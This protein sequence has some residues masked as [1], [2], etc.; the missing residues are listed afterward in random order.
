MADKSDGTG[1]VPARKKGRL[2]LVLG[3]VLMLA[4]GGGGFYAVWSGLLF[5]S[6]GAATEASAGEAGGALPDIAFVAL[7]PLIVSINGGGEKSYL[8]FAAQLEVAKAQEEEVR[9]ILPR[10]LDVLN[11]YL[12][13]VEISE[14]EKPTALVK[15][16]AQLVR[17]IQLVAGE[18]RVRDLLVTEF[19]IN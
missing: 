10:V 8:R 11:S 16:R 7:D 14:L 15:L 1:E 18:G 13:A 5:G 9:L 12:R 17:R 3:V 6:G 4:L 2:P 19:V